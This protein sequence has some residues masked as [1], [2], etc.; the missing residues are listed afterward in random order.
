[1]PT[2]PLKH[3]ETGEEKEFFPLDEPREKRYYYAIA[4]K[5]LSTEKELHRKIMNQ[6]KEK[7]G[8]DLG[9]SYAIYSTDYEY[10]FG[11]VLSFS[12]KIQE[13]A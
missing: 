3:K 4:K 10:D 5:R 11:Y 1:M 7:V 6:V 8:D 2:Y 9:V 12:Q 13:T